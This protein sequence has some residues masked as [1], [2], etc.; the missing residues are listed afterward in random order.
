M[1]LID[2][3]IVIDHF[4]AN[5]QAFDY[6][7]Q[8]LALGETLAVSAITVTEITAGMRQ[9]EEDRTQRLLSLFVVLDVS[10]AIALHAGAYLRDFRR[11]KGLEI[12]DALIAAT[13]KHHNIQLVTRNLRHYPMADIVVEVPYERGK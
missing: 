9:G 6:F 12:A 13:A 7:A 10:D 1:K 5:Q 4:H 11:V 2:S 3:D 8:Q